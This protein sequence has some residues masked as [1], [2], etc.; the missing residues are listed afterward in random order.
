MLQK[1]LMGFWVGGRLFIIQPVYVRNSGDQLLMM[2][3]IYLFIT[4]LVNI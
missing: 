4:V 1:E 3:L 2:R